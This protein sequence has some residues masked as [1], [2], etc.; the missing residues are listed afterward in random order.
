MNAHASYDALYWDATGDQWNLPIGRAAV[1][2][3]A[4]A[5]P[6]DAFC[7]A[8]PYGS[9]SSC[10]RTRITAGAATF[11]QTGLGPHEGLGGAADISKG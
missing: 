2:V 11:I 9:N 4:P 5:T 7:W 6:I 10:Q 8:G 3:T 1:R